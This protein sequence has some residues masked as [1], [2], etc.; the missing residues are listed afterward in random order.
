MEFF[1]VSFVILRASVV[2]SLCPVSCIASSRA[3]SCGG[4]LLAAGQC[5]RRDGWTHGN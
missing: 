4:F 2:E 1:F 3:V 5:G